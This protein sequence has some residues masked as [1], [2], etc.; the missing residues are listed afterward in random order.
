M[1]K[2]SQHSAN[3]SKLLA[4]VLVIVP[5][6]ILTSDEVISMFQLGLQAGNAGL[7]RL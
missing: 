6:Q 4:A 1:Q 3:A 5:H 7:Q 2:N